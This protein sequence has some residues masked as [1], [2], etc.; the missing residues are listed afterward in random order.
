MKKRKRAPTD[1]ECGMILA[2]H[3]LILR[4]EESLAY[5]VLDEAGARSFSLRT[6]EL[7]DRPMV[8]DYQE[9]RRSR[10]SIRRELARC[11]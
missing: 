10:D 9:N 7:P 2:A 1:F 8:R 11:S 6:I 4:G 5:E 3:H